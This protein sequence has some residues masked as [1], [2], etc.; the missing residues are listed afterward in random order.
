MQPVTNV[1]RKSIP[2]KIRLQVWEKYNHHCAYCGCELKYKEMQV[3]HITSKYWNNGVDDISNYNP[4][5]RMCNFYKS[6]LSL[7]GFREQLQTI[8]KRLEKIFIYRL[9]KKYGI[10]T[11]NKEQIEFYF[12]RFQCLEGQMLRDKE[13]KEKKESTERSNINVSRG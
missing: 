13:R 4:A 3:D 12:E 6:T 9:A 11:E 8:H 5:C 10:I 7:E 1:K 2:K